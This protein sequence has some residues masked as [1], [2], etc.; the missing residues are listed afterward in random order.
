MSRARVVVVA[1]VLVLGPQLAAAQDLSRY[2][3]Y[4]LESSLE[5][6]IAASGARA[7]DVRTLHERPARIRELQWRAPYESSQ[8]QR[9]DPVRGAV[10]TFY[11][12]A[13][14]QIVVSY[15]RE[16]TNGLTNADLLESLTAVYGA[17]VLKSARSRPSAASPD[18]VVVAQWDG[19]TS[20]LSLLRGVYTPEFQLV[21]ISKTLSTRARD[22]IREAGRLDVIEAPRR[23]LEQRKQ[24]IADANAARD[25]ARTTNK[26][27][28]RP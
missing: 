2:R 7:A 23:E 13:L 21:L 6:V 4:A 5:S 14:Y 1:L 27:A 9:A 19:P 16:R 3:A 10:F 12:D 26:G 17:P 11:D 15:D 24:E 20:S 25:K 8:S 22:A 28:F 18:S